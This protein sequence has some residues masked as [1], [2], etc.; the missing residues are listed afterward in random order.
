MGCGELCHDR[1]GGLLLAG[2]TRRS[3]ASGSDAEG[4]VVQAPHLSPGFRDFG[5][6]KF[7]MGNARKGM[8]DISST[9]ENRRVSITYVWRKF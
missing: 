1:F 3:G 2:H 5:R 6:V 8:K 9:A 4:A 7:M